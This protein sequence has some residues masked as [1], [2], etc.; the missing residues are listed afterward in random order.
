MSKDNRAIDQTSTGGYVRPPD[1]WEPAHVT[2]DVAAQMDAAVRSRIATVA[3]ALRIT[4]RRAAIAVLGELS[5]QAIDVAAID[6]CRK[7]N[8]EIMDALRQSMVLLEIAEAGRVEAASQ[9]ALAMQ[10][11]GEALVGWDMEKSQRRSRLDTLSDEQLASL[12]RQIMDAAVDAEASY[13]RYD[14]ARRLRVAMRLS[15]L[16]ADRDRAIEMGHDFSDACEVAEAE[17]ARITALHA[18][19]RCE[20]EIFVLK[21]DLAAARDDEDGTN[22]R[23]QKLRADFAAVERSCVAFRDEIDT[24]KVRLASLTGSAY[25]HGPSLADHVARVAAW[26]DCQVIEVGGVAFLRHDHGAFTVVP[27]M[28]GITTRMVGADRGSV[29]G[30]VV[31]E[32][33]GEIG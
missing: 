17:T 18:D 6:A 2:A 27:K 8:E 12:K 1:G 9:L 30:V 11:G 23:Y 10:W 5:G 14:Y 33:D 26:K 29:S 20:A 21:R 24:A 28:V 13:D 19:S 7:V 3:A 32:D 22:K 16:E 25:V 4:E 15:L 31:E